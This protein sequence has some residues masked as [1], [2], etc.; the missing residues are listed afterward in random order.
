M[1][2]LLS[3]LKTMKEFQQLRQSVCA[4]SCAAVTGVSQICRSHLIAG[5]YAQ[6]SKPITVICQDDAAA[7]RLQQDLASFL[8]AEVPVLCSRELTLYDSAVVS[9][10]WEQKR[11]RQLYDLARGATRLQIMTW[12][13]LSQRTIP[14][15]VLLNSALT[16]QSG[17][18]YELDTLIQT[19]TDAGYSH[20]AMVEGPGQYA[21]RG[22]ILD[23]YSPACDSPVRA[24]FFGDELDTMG[25]FDP[26]SQRRTENTDS[27]TIL[28]VGETQPRLHPEGLE[29]LC[30]DISRLI[31]TQK[32]RNHTL[33]ALI[34]TLEND[35][36]KYENNLSN[37][38]S[39]RYMGFI[40]PEF[41][42]AFDYIPEGSIVVLCEQANL[43][44][45]AKT[46]VQDMG[47]QLDSMLQAGI[48]A[49][50]LCDYVSLWEDFCHQLQGRS[51]VYMDTFAGAAYP[52]EC[53]PKLLLPLLAKQLPGYGGNLDIA[54]A[55]LGHYQ[56]IGFSSLV[57]CSFPRISKHP[58]P[59]PWFSCPNLDRSI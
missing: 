26:A 51:V 56:Q 39:D 58:S 59:F 4:G 32:R 1:D 55:D 44:R 29:G 47:M 5:L 40:Y 27:F 42:T 23:I 20:C 30:R 41:A 6:T 57:L 43:H 7:K 54:A 34:P 52:E 17:A 13:A 50:E 22:G 9:R 53:P 46:R 28:P 8:A 14:R 19:L 11:L 12:D 18:Q 33:E 10:A 21:V 35:L 36:H 25:Y 15:D 48:L 31:A 2:Q 3:V 49:G 38:A 45:S 37:P 16:L 24:E